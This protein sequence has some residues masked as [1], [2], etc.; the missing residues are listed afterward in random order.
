MASLKSAARR[1]RAAPALLA[2]FA[3]ALT[4]TLALTVSHHDP[5]LPLA[6]GAAVRAALRDPRTIRALEGTH[7]HADATAIDGQLERVSFFAHGR[8]VA[9]TAVGR[10]GQVAEII[11]YEG[12]RVPYG[13]WIAY[14]PGL[15][16]ALAAVFLMVVGV[17]P[18]RRMRNLD[19]IAV[20][21][22]LAPVVLL[23]YRYLDASVVASLPGLG[24]LFFRCVSKALGRSREPLPAI[25]LIAALTPS[26]DV[27]NRVRLLRILVVAIALIYVMVG[28][29]SG[30]AVDVIYAV[31][32]GATKI[33]H[34]VLPYGHMPGDVIHGDTY[35]ILSYLLYTP[36][37][38]IAPVNSNW[39]S[40]D[41]ALALGVAA[42]LVTA[43]GLFR[44]TAGALGR[45]GP[46][47]PPEVEE[48]GLRA[49]LA[50]LAFPPLA[51]TVSTGTTDVPLAAMLFGVVLLWRRPVLSTGLLT[52]AGW[53][54]LA[55]FAL[56]P[57]W[58][59]PLRGR[60]LAAASVAVVAVSAPL[61]GALIALGGIGAPA[62]M[63]HAVSYQFTRGSLQSAWAALGIPNLQPVGEGCVLGLIAAAVVKLRSEP[64]LAGD[65]V[66][67]AALSAAVLVGL[68]LSADYWAFLYE[69]WVLPLLCISVLASPSP[70]A[71][72][73]R[74]TAVPAVS[75]VA[76]AAAG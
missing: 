45:L 69:I 49:A 5:G 7:W 30:G 14:E 50:W 28:V 72:T 35:P 1:L 25:P 73:A 51:I 13:S 8:I 66:R 40:V 37:A 61:V 18:L 24:Y 76:T 10:N 26:L 60:R 74:R 31:M 57:V 65:R 71:E 6:P 64:E 32:E 23:Q 16:V 52:A 59:A 34:G 2:A 21:S 22:L 17:A 62:A 70:A 63:I 9:E 43:W 54:K 58:L 4:A 46:A 48:A 27:A 39:D 55:P 68:Q 67:I 53:F 36:L 44:V 47:R 19:A 29:S 20:L 15:L 12:L 33:V 38:W 75:P 56:I 3:V 11:S 42:A 41:G